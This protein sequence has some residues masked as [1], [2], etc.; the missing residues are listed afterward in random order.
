MLKGYKTLG[1]G[2]LLTIL[3]FLQGFDFTTIISDP[4]T[5]G[6]VTSGIGIIVMIL[7]TLTNTPVPPIGKK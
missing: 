4:E 5:V 6:Y 1:F 2:L 3:G 7:R